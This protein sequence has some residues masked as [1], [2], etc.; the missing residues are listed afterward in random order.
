MGETRPATYRDVGGGRR[1]G[2]TQYRVSTAALPSERA[3]TYRHD[4][5][6][7][8]RPFVFLILFTSLGWRRKEHFVCVDGHCRVAPRKALITFLDLMRATEM[9][10]LT[11]CILVWRR[12]LLDNLEDA[13]PKSSSLLGPR[14]H[15]GTPGKRL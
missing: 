9:T 1:S 4:V 13:S 3:P 5:P 12:P 7:A 6:A 8:L 2:F 14:A 11:T 15:D 10:L